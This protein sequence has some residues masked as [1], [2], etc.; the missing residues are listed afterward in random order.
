MY[1]AGFIAPWY[2]RP[3]QKKFFEMLLNKKKVVAKAHRR[4]GKGT[5]VLVYAITKATQNPNFII[6]YGGPTQKMAYEIIDLLLTHIYDPAP[7]EK[8]KY[9]DGSY[10]W[11]NGSRIYIF[12]CGDAAEADKARGTEAH[13]IIADEYAFWKYRPEYILNS[14]LGPQTDTTNGQI[15]ITSTPPFDLTHPYLMEV[16]NAKLDN[17]LFDWNINDSLKTGEVSKATHARIVERCRGMDTDTYR[18]EYLCQMIADKSKLIIPEAQN[19]ALWEGEAPE[20]PPYFNWL[21]M[22]DF[23]FVDFAAGLWAYVDF[24]RSRLIIVGEYFD[25]YKSTKEIV[26]AAEEIEKRLGINTK[27]IV[28]RGDCSDPQQL[29]DLSHDHGYAISG[30]VKRSQQSNVGFRESVLNQLRLAIVDG[31]ILVDKKLAPN[32]YLQLKFGMWNERRTD[33]ERTTTLG[34]LDALMAMAYLVD[35]T[36][37]KSNP[38]P[39]RPP[40]INHR[41]FLIDER[42]FKPTWAKQIASIAGRFSK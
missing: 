11:P 4:W 7:K 42:K 36:D 10:V 1:Q 40:E 35:N 27:K 33:F 21:C 28:R 12:G 32:L 19:E 30:I 13:L 24:Y 25:R 31:K 20:K 37:F 39:I 38:F 23:G 6:R 14:V 15:L 3:S 5:T 17:N 29:F 2:L 34:H 41:D 8:P 16:E 18:R 9:K 22:W 26:T